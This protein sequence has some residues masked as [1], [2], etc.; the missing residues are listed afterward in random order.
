MYHRAIRTTTIVTSGKTRHVGDSPYYLAYINCL[1]QL[2]D[3]HPCAVVQS[4]VPIPL[5][6]LWLCASLRRNL[7]ETNASPWTSWRCSIDCPLCAI[8]CVIHTQW[9]SDRNYTKAQKCD[10]RGEKK[11]GAG[12]GEGFNPVFGMTPCTRPH[13]HFSRVSSAIP[14]MCTLPAILWHGTV[15][16]PLS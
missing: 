16:F 13:K 10:K 7:W 3:D 9:P 2:A 4:L 5:I 15:R 1:E 8:A 6:D 14:S 11:E 12:G